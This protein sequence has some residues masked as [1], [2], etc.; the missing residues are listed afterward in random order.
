MAS[1][2]RII[3]TVTNK[4]YI[5]KTKGT[6]KNRWRDHMYKL[7]KGISRCTYLQATWNKYGEQNFKFE[8]ILSG[9]FSKEELSRLEVEYIKIYG[10]YNII[11]SVQSNEY[12][13]TLW[14]KHYEDV[15]EYWRDKRNGAGRCNHPGKIRVSKK[16]G[17]S[18]A[19]AELMLQKLRQEHV[20]V[21][22]YDRRAIFDYWLDPANHNK[23]ADNITPGYRIISDTFNI[24]VHESR[25]LIKQFK[26]EYPTINSRPYHNMK[27]YYDVKDY[28]SQKKVGARTIAKHF[29]IARGQAQSILKLIHN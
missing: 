12:T 19:T 22:T 9:N 11:D 18:E 15:K 8:V 6:P 7:R 3:N 10:D 17:I 28:I 5:G 1:I 16:F 29:G 14:D 4:M 25:R 24:S 21:L 26:Q 2:Y 23:K 27:L 13:D 20:E